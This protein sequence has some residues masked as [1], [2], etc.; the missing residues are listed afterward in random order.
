MNDWKRAAAEAAALL[1]SDGM[2]VGLGSG[3]TA[4]MVVAALGRRVAE[5]LRF[6]G[7]PTSEKTA[8][9]ARGLGIGLAT[10]EEFPVLDLAIDG[11]DEV[12]ASS[13]FLIKGGGGNQLR[14][15]LVAVASARFVIAV[16]ERKVVERL[17]MAAP[18]PV[19]VV[20]F[21]W[22]STARRLEALGA[23]PVQR[24]DAQGAPFVTD[25]GNYVLD[26][27]FGAIAAP[28]ELAVKLDGVVGV[29]EH[30]LFLDMATQVIVGGADGVR[31]LAAHTPDRL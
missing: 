20:T 4:E 26:C 15:K 9:L 30:G 3:S 13:F 7:I 12:E 2:A 31:E 18:V 17:G 19:E 25:G 21:G 22:K 11:A 16:D 28:R 23:R 6:T 8:A 5:G 24:L 14:E 10:L 29:V 1:V 27:G